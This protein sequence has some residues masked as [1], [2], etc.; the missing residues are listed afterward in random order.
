M[1]RWLPL[2][3]VAS[4]ASRDQSL[5]RQL[6]RA[7]AELEAVR[8]Q[9]GQIL[10]VTSTMNS[11]IDKLEDRSDQLSTKIDGLGKSVAMVAARAQQPT[12]APV[13]LP[14]EPDPFATYSVP[15]A[16]SPVEGKD[17]AKITLVEFTD[18]ACPFCLRSRDTLSLLKQKYGD[19]LRVVH[20]DLIVHAAAATDA[21]FAACAAGRQ[22]KWFEMA[23]L[24]WTKGWNGTAIGDI[25]A[26][27]GSLFAAELGLDI[28][29]FKKDTSGA[30]CRK[31]IADDAALAA[32]LGVRGTPSFYVNGR[33]LAGAQ[34]V[35]V[36]IK[37]MD[38][39]QAKAAASKLHGSDYYD[40]LVKSGK[41][42]LK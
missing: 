2:V 41:T 8:Q 1:N 16:G 6:D 21:A 4:C 20:K 37:L 5:H 25:S 24:F 18:F 35:D 42:S 10:D 17:S 38:E 19:D 9:N 14:P 39:E 7:L 31:R 36:F 28:D 11:R 26:G 22:G 3:V 15:I 40:S 23:H 32:Q 12:P 27:A 34:P 13:P 33:F 29:K 30:D